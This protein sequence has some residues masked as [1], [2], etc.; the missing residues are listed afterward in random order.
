MSHYT[1]SDEA[2]N[3]VQGPESMAVWPYRTFSQ[4][5]SVTTSSASGLGV[6]CVCVCV[7]VKKNEIFYAMSWKKKY[8][9][10]CYYSLT[11]SNFSLMI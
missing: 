9:K 5:N 4:S 3:S 10:R 2:Q 11:E 6:G 7:C 1:H 8:R